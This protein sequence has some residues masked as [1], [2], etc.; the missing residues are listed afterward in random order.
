MFECVDENK[1]N[2][3]INKCMSIERV[4]PQ[5]ISVDS[6]NTQVKFCDS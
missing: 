4:I 6:L 3:G 2:H 5:I 1:R